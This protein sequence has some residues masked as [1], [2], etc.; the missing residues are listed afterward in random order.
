MILHRY[1]WFL[2]TTKRLTGRR[3]SSSNLVAFAGFH[4]NHPALSVNPNERGRSDDWRKKALSLVL[5]RDEGAPVVK[6]NA[7]LLLA[8]RVT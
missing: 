3:K 5:A 6:T 7:V 8:S 1:P 4:T 2:R